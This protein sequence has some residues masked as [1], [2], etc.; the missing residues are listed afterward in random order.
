LIRLGGSDMPWK[1]FVYML[2]IL[3]G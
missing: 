1:L 3:Y 2:I